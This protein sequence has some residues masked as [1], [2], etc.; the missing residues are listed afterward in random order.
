MRICRRDIL[1]LLVVCL[2]HCILANAQPLKFKWTCIDVD[3]QVLE[4]GDL[5]ISERQDYAFE[6]G[7]AEQQHELS[8]LFLMDRIEEIRDIEILE[9]AENG[10][11]AESGPLSYDIEADQNDLRICW[12]CE[13]DPPATRTF[14]LKYRVIGAICVDKG[15]GGTRYRSRR[16]R[17]RSLMRPSWDELYW[18]AVVWPRPAV[19]EKAKVTVHLPPQLRG[20]NRQ[21]RSYGSTA[22]IRRGTDPDTIGFDSIS[23]IPRETG[24]QIYVAFEHGILKIERPAWQPDEHPGRRLWLS[25][26]VILLTVV[27]AAIGVIVDFFKRRCPYCGKTWGLK[28]TGERENLNAGK[29]YWFLRDDICLYKCKA[30]DYKEWKRRGSGGC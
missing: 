10:K 17:R 15:E 13:L 29:I 8:R 1:I 9:L 26:P 14:L 16:S 30:C 28:Y 12:S 23:R 24:L 6:G 27:C 20:K 22:A 3:I 4:D 7:P 5:L 21:V 2:F 11:T 19:V 18:N 25:K